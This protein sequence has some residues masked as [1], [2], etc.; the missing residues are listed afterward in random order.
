MFFYQIEYMSWLVY[1][2]SSTY[3]VIAASNATICL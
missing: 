1:P 2:T 3:R